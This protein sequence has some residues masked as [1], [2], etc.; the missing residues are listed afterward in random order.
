MVVLFRS[1]SKDQVRSERI[2]WLN[3]LLPLR[4]SSNTQ[5]DRTDYLKF[6][7]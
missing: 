1:Y 4:G 6:R 7:S 5:Y 2:C 3:V